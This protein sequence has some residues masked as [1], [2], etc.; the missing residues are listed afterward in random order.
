MTTKATSIDWAGVLA[1]TE[2]MIALLRDRYV[3]KGWKLDGD[4]AVKTLQYFESQ[5]A[6]Q[7]ENDVEQRQAF[8]FIYSH[9]QSLDWIICGDP[10]G[11][12]C[13][14]ASRSPRAAG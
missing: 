8:D 5:A 9:G 4:A 12:I 11:M 2:Q 14:L 7:C 3:A 6:G 10:A 13:T 1:R